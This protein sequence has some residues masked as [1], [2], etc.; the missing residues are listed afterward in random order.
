[1][2]KVSKKQR[3]LTAL[4]N[5][6]NISPWYAIN[7]LGDTRLSAT[8]FQLKKDGYNITSKTEKSKN[9]FGDTISYSRYF[10]GR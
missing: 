5:H 3:V 10:L 7:N 4:E 9:K 8:I 6:G 1:M 2:S